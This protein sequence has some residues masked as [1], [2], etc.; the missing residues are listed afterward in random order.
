MKLRGENGSG[1]FWQ[2]GRRRLVEMEERKFSSQE[3]KKDGVGWYIRAG[4]TR[5]GC[6]SSHCIVDA[7]AGQVK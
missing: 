7:D 1:G 3:R 2:E 5:R 6:K 4:L